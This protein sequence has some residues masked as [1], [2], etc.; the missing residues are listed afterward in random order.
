MW[1]YSYVESNEQTELTGKTETDSQIESRWQLGGRVGAG[2]IEQKGKRT[3]GHGQ[4]C[5]DCGGLGG[6]RGLNG[7]RKKK[8]KQKQNPRKPKQTKKKINLPND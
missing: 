7:N 1:F 5:G 3:H 6:I 4:Q 8:I 2:R